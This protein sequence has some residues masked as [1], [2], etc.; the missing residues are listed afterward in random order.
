M[1]NEEITRTME[2]ILGQQAQIAASLQRHDEERIRD[3]PRLARVEESFQLLVKLAQNTDSR[4]DRVETKT[5]DLE[6]HFQRLDEER[7]RDKPRLARV[8]ESFQLLVK[9]AQ[10][11]DS[12]LDR[13]E[14]KTSDPEDNE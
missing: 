3:R 1:T 7:I 2:F 14:T 5:S 12:K 9:L 10:S 8:E 13:V 6:A 4:L 11:I